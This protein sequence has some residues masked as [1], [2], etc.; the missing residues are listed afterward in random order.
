MSVISEINRNASISRAALERLFMTFVQ[1]PDFPCV[2]AKSAVSAGSY[3][4]RAY[5]RLAHPHS[6]ERLAV[7]LRHFQ[8]SELRATAA[9]ATFV[10]IFRA[11]RVINEE[12]FE[13][14]L[15]SQLQQLHDIDCARYDWDDSVSSNPADPH[16]SFSFAGKAFYVVGMH[17]T[18]SRLARRFAFPAMIFNPHEQFERLRNEGHW[19]KMQATIR[20]RDMALQGNIN[21]MLSDFGET[22][23]A[24]QYSGR[25]V[26]DDWS[27]PF[28]KRVGSGAGRCP[29]A[30]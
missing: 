16:F 17:P 27:P 19:R 13:V 6:S 4:V 28:E 5:D 23:E 2:G 3:C 11:P 20:E 9:Y 8:N 21:P 15:W 1:R 30:H 29:F 25:A 24:R 14:L 26:A 22:S 10:A 7:D 18:S 12:A